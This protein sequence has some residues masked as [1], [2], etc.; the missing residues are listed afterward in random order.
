M[1]TKKSCYDFSEVKKYT[2]K[3]NSLLKCLHMLC[4]WL[5]LYL[6]IYGRNVAND[7]NLRMNMKAGLITAFLP[8]LDLGPP[9]LIA[10]FN[11]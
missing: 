6:L 11:F 5:G 3:Y 8:D 1:N 4:W 10:I 9:L 2:Q 7:V